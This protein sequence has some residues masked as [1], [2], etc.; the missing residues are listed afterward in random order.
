MAKETGW[1]VGEI[2][3][4]GYRRLVPSPRPVEIVEK[5]DIKRLIDEGSIVIAA[6]GGGVPVLAGRGGGLT[7]LDGVIDKDLA[8][9]VLAKDIGAG[10]LLIVTDVDRVH[11]NHGTPEEKEIE[12]MNISDARDYLESGHFPSG[13][14]GPKIEAAVQFL[15]SGGKEVIITSMRLAR[16]SLDG[17]AGTKIVP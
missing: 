15:E 17:G 1:T 11:L 12:T 2:K 5:E 16:K 8:A 10:L 3:G 9:G 4:K 6:G 13:S 14:M 7:G